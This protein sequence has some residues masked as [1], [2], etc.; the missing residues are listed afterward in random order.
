MNIYLVT[1]VSEKAGFLWGSPGF[2]TST[3][4]TELGTWAIKGT[5]SIHSR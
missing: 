3:C 2:R 1:E 4:N 5:E